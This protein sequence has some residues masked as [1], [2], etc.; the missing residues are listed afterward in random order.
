[1][2]RKLFITSSSANTRCPPLTG[3]MIR[4]RTRSMLKGDR[5]FLKLNEIKH[6]KCS[7]YWTLSFIIQFIVYVHHYVQYEPA[8]R[9]KHC[10]R[11]LQNLVGDNVKKMFITYSSAATRYPPPTDIMI[12]WCRKAM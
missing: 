7:N 5:A 2:S 6:S 12:R 3:I 8:T 10:Q 1:M 4:W 11:L 9:G